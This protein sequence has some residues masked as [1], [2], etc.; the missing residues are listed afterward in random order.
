MIPMKDKQLTENVKNGKCVIQKRNR[1][2]GWLTFD[3]RVLV[4]LEDL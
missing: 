4:F 3:E 2:A 1:V